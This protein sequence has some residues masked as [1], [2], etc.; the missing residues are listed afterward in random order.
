MRLYI[1][2]AY[3][4]C[5]LF[6][7]ASR[8]TYT[9]LRVFHLDLNEITCTQEYFFSKE[10]LQELDRLWGKMASLWETRFRSESES[11]LEVWI[12]SIFIFRRIFSIKL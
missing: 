8:F 10:I 2:R 9:Q 1:S 7:F 6:T 4:Y 11:S 3:F 12:E 5:L